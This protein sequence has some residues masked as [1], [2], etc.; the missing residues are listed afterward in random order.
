MPPSSPYLPTIIVY[1]ASLWNNYRKARLLLLNIIMRCYRRINDYA[2]GPEIDALIHKDVAELTAGIVSSIPYLL[3]ADLQAF[4]ENTNAE[5]PPL[6]P[7]RPI[8]GLLLM[9]ALY[10]LLTLPMVEARLKA[11]IRHCLAWIG[12]RMGIGQATILS[13]V[14]YS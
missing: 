8:G 9:H 7:G 13:R 1:V 6:V 2:N 10:V 5:L 12:T 11:Y 3:A 14:R 4:V